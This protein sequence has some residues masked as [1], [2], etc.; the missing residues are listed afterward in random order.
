MTRH[1]FPLAEYIP[2]C[3]GYTCPGDRD[4]CRRFTERGLG[5]PYKYWT[6]G[7]RAADGGTACSQRIGFVHAGQAV[8]NVNPA[9]ATNAV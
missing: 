3:G 7:D 2:R 9:G 1:F 4:Q 8:Q 5:S 6:H